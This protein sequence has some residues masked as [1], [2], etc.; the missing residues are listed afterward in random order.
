MGFDEVKVNAIKEESLIIRYFSPLT[1]WGLRTDRVLEL[2]HFESSLKRATET[3]LPV[4]IP[5]PIG[6][7]ASCHTLVS[8]LFE[9]GQRREVTTGRSGPVKHLQCLLQ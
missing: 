7:I 4:A 3:W 1:R 9:L 2:R 8:L 6:G 5:P